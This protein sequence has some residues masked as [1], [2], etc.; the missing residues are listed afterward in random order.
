[1]G[2]GAALLPWGKYASGM[3][4]LILNHAVLNTL[5]MYC[6][7]DLCLLTAW[8]T[9]IWEV[10]AQVS[11]RIHPHIVTAQ[12]SPACGFNGCANQDACALTDLYH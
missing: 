9:P 8:N 3:L 1:M 7:G 4:F 2:L 10:A 6:W 11:R 5:F 12:V